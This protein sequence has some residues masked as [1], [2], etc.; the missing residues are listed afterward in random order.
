LR[1][2]NIFYTRSVSVHDGALN[3]FIREQLADGKD[4]PH[5]L[6]KLFTGRRAKITR[7][8]NG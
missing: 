2:R 6:F 8:V 4:V 1:E 3:S 7:G 5:D